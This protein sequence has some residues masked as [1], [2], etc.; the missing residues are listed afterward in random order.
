MPL[1]KSAL[2]I[3][4]GAALFSLNAGED[5]YQETIK[6]FKAMEGGPPLPAGTRTFSFPDIAKQSVSFISDT[7][8]RIAGL[9]AFSGEVA[10]NVDDGSGSGGFSVSVATM[11]TGHDGRDKKTENSEWLVSA[12]QELLQSRSLRN[13]SIIVMIGSGTAAL[14]LRAAWLLLRRC[15]P[16]T[17]A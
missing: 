3:G 14:I 4:A 10:F 12:N 15:S 17:Q 1:I 6:A 11:K 16:A 8:E 5:E 2:L 13:I 7:K 9:I